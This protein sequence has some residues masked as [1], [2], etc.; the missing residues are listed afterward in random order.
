MDVSRQRQPCD[1]TDDNR[2]QSAYGSGVDSLAKRLQWCVD[3]KGKSARALSVA[4]GLGETTVGKIISR[5]STRVAPEDVFA[6]ARAAGVNGVWLLLGDAFAAR[7][8]EAH[9]VE[10][11]QESPATVPVRVRPSTD[12]R[13]VL[14]GES[15]LGWAFDPTRH[16]ARDFRAVHDLLG[17]TLEEAPSALMQTVARKWLDAAAEL[18]RSGQSVTV[19]AILLRVTLGSIEPVG[20]G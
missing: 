12:G 3:H 20:A 7:E 6:L 10:P 15:G 14:P 9:A 5:G 1:K 11:P 8:G 2:R 18:R 17:A 16:I 19:E 13:E 4:A